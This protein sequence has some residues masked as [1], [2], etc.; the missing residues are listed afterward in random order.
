MLLLYVDDIIISS[1]NS[2]HSEAVNDYLDAW[3]HINDL[4]SVKYFLGLQVVQSPDGIVLSQCK[5]TLDISQDACLLG[6]KLV[7]SPMEQIT[8]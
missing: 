3:F 2:A 5:Y 1:D 7:S 8:N 4:G 6:C